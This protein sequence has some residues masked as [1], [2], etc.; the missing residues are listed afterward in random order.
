MI[1]L[2]LLAVNLTALILVPSAAHL[3]E[4]PGK[5]SLERDAYFIVQ[6][7]Y[8]GWALFG[9][10]ILAAITANGALA[11]A[12]RRRDPVA[13]RWA[14]VSATLIA[15]SLAVFFI[16]VFP[17]NQATA[18]WTRQPAAWEELRRQW[19]YGHAVNAGIVWLAFLAT[20]I[21]SS[22]RR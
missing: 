19:E 10:A 6:G 15:V 13:A 4:L 16:W 12:E 22:R 1:F 21:A 8:A 5:I 3:F 17:A 11:F 7:I 18:N 2:R 9:V 14:A 20:S